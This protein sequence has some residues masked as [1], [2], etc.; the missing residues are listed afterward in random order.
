M[1]GQTLLSFTPNGFTSYCIHLIFD[2]ISDP[3]VTEKLWIR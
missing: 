3:E 1:M 2:K